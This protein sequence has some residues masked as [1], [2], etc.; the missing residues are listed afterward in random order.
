MFKK[1]GIH[2]RSA[3]IFDARTRSFKEVTLDPTTNQFALVAPPSESHVSRMEFSARTALI[4]P[5][6]NTTNRSW[7]NP[8]RPIQLTADKS[9]QA[10]GGIMAAD[11]DNRRFHRSSIY[12]PN[13]MPHHRSQGAQ[14]ARRYINGQA[15]PS[16]EDSPRGQ[17]TRGLPPAAL[18]QRIDAHY[19]TRGA[20]SYRPHSAQ[21]SA[22]QISINQSVGM[23]HHFMKMVSTGRLW[24]TPGVHGH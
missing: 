11:S 5:R 7:Q 22:G 9:W 1:R 4:N 3:Q 21:Q 13:S 15:L 23:K 18:R 12:F 14:T 2:A 16:L 20:P 6:S 17:Q 19:H 10:A 24:D 8:E